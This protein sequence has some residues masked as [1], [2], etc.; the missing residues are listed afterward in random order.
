MD[1]EK[2]RAYMEIINLRNLNFS[3]KRAKE[4]IRY[5]RDNPLNQ[6]G[7]HYRTS[8]TLHPIVALGDFQI[9]YDLGFRAW[10][11]EIKTT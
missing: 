10:M 1:Y 7:Q 2:I 6:C 4:L 8:I 5:I 11:L 9:Q 3:R